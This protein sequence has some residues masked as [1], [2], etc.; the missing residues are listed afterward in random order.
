MTNRRVRFTQILLYSEHKAKE[1]CRSAI[2]DRL[3]TS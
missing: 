1:H 3:L 2:V